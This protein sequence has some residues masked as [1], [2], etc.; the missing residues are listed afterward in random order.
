LKILLVEDNP[1][2]QLMA[3]GTLAFLGHEVV[4]AADGQQAVNSATTDTFDLIL[5][6]LMLP[7]MDG[8]QASQTILKHFQEKGQPPTPIVALTAHLDDAERERCRQHGLSRW[9]TKP[10]S[11]EEFQALVS[12]LATDQGSEPPGES[13]GNSDAGS[14]AGSPSQID[15]AELW[16]RVKD[17]QALSKIVDLFSHTYPQRLVEVERSLSPAGALEAKRALHTLRGN[18]LNFGASRA[19]QVAHDLTLAVEEYRWDQV[20]HGLPD[21]AANCSAVEKALRQALADHPA[22][23]APSAEPTSAPGVGF[24]VVVA[25]GDP[26]SLALCAAYLR[27]GGYEVL[28]ASDGSQVLDHLA[29]SE[30]DVVVMGVMMP[31]LDGFETC[32]RIKASPSSCMIPVLLLTGLDERSS[33]LEGMEA[34]ADDFLIKPFDPAEAALRV[35]NAARGKALYDRLE[36]S[37]QELQQLEQLRDGLTHMLVHD[38]R[39][40][41]TIVKGYATILSSD[42]STGLTEQ[43]K[44]FAEKMLMQSNRLVEMVSA[45]LDV[46]RLESD[47]LELNS[48]EVDLAELLRAE[49]EPMMGLPEYLLELQLAEGVRCHCDRDLVRRVV[50]NLLANAFKYTPKGTPVTLIMDSQQDL[51]TVAVIDQGPGVPLGSREKIFE[52]FGQVEGATHR[53]PYSS[54]LGLTFCQLVVQ[55]HGGQI[56]VDDGPGGVG[57]RFWF[58]LPLAPGR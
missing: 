8:Y 13:L 11:P 25:D 6:D 22:S 56:A 32:R 17:P 42:L 37:Y 14:A 4:V 2:N 34:G 27:A 30:V 54:G 7:V 57:S 46:N 38:L 1:V 21:L 28:E 31:G 35:R 29:Q 47:Q 36:H 10:I 40:P 26:A 51:A 44:A 50:G 9:L 41:L 49:V 58:T 18:F 20:R 19:A 12:S 15:A 39:G 48:E 55:K 3:Q 24:T 23:P 52:K 33:R 53:R 5:M 45:I 43:Q 16:R